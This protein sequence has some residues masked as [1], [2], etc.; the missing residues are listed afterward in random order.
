[1]SDNYGKFLCYS[2]DQQIAMI[3]SADL[4]VYVNGADRQRAEQCYRY[5]ANQWKSNVSDDQ[6]DLFPNSIPFGCRV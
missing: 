1:M 6:A 2:A 4:R 5:S 3:N